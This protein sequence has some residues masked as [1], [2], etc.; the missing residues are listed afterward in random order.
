MNEYNT[1]VIEYSRDGS[2]RRITIDKGIDRLLFEYNYYKTGVK[3][4]NN[5]MIITQVDGF[6]V[7]KWNEEN[8][9]YETYEEVYIINGGLE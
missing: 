8:M 5:Y 9:S 1:K 3:T 2:V 7:K 6:T 4:D